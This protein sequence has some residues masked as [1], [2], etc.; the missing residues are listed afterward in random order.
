M[1]LRILVALLALGQIAAPLQAGW[2]DSLASYFYKPDPK[3]PKIRVLIVYDKPGVVLEVKGMY[4]LYDPLT[5]EHISTR[6]VGK[7]KFIQAVQDGLK[8]GEEFPGVHQLLVVPDEKSTTTIVDGIEYR[9]PIYVYDVGG[10]ISVV[11][12]ISIENYLS[13]IL[14][15]RHPQ[16]NS[17]EFLAAIAIAAR[18]AAYYAIEHPKSQYWEVDGRQ[19]GYQGYAVV[20]ES[21]DIEKAIHDTRY[22]VMSN[23]PTGIQAFPAQ[24]SRGQG[25]SPGLLSNISLEQATEM[26]RQ[27]ANAAQIL[28]KA[29]PGI[30]IELIHYAQEKHK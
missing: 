9:G 7:R 20:E 27:G 16:K 10:T 23:S 24:W 30:K 8:W 13:S 19:V 11:N 1:M 21:S 17:P 15:E 14:A 29:F 18:T 12:E 4:K 6:Y 3:P 26:A 5:G 2:F 28:E 22:M 25:S